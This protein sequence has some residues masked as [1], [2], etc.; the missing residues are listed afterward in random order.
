MANFNL[1]LSG[2]GDA[3][4]IRE[5]FNSIVNAIE[6]VAGTLEVDGVPYDAADV[7][8]PEDAEADDDATDDTAEAEDDA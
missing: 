3:D 4:D 8:E 1:T 6:S 7:P 2:E 5:A